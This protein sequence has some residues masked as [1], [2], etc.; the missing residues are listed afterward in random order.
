MR[1]FQI[2]CKSNEADV[3]IGEWLRKGR[4]DFDGSALT[5][6][7]ERNP[8]DVFLYFATRNSV[9]KLTNMKNGV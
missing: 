9:K 3:R 1:W 4:A 5:L 8:G 2:L 7:K 6:T